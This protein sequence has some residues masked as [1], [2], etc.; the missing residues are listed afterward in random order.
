[1]SAKRWLVSIIR[2]GPFDKAEQ[3]LCLPGRCLRYN[4]ITSMQMDLPASRSELVA[5]RQ[6]LLNWWET[7][8]HAR[9]YPWRKPE[10]RTPYRAVVAELMLRRTRADQ[11][12]AV[13]QRFL[14]Q[15]PTLAD[16]F[17]ADPA[18]M[19]QILYPLGL[20][21]RA[22]SILEFLKTAYN[23]FG[24]NLPV[25]AEK[26]RTLPGV[27]DYVGAAVQVF[28]GGEPAVLI[29]VNVVRV[30]GRV[31]GLDYSG[32]ARRRK[33]MRQLAMAAADPNRSA[34][35]HYAILDFAAKVC[36]AGRPRC[37]QCPLATM[38]LCV[39][40]RCSDATHKARCADKP[41]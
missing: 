34:E 19:K 26:L 28:A 15:Y 32:E 24:E 14:E 35:Y 11:V 6:V 12:V 33:P 18:V 3:F 8:D 41:E 38:D 23:T 37:E 39:Y 22:D 20:E 31:F 1:M 5:L 10:N 9:S 17:A 25:D 27:G 13:Y 21:W 29:D 40:Y 16:A 30:L 4:T 2:W 36:V 7:D